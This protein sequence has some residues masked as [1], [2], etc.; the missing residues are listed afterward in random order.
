ML[1][2]P[3]LTKCNFPPLNA[4]KLEAEIH[5]EIRIQIIK[6]DAFVL[7]AVQARIKKAPDIRAP[8]FNKI[9]KILPKRKN[10]H[11]ICRKTPG[12]R[13]F[14]PASTKHYL[15]T[16]IQRGF[17]F[18]F[19][20]PRCVFPRVPRELFPHLWHFITSPTLH[21]WEKFSTLSFN[22]PR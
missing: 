12:P 14:P 18:H 7:N 5:D 15:G 11:L 16:L 22:F 10:P 8:G 1:S 13:D 19:Y 4:G 9:T 20:I 17:M 2:K 3:V 6:K 21:A